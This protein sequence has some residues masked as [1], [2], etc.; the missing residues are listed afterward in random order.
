MTNLLTIESFA[1][2]LEVNRLIT[3]VAHQSDNVGK[4]YYNDLCE[5]F[6]A[7][8]Y[9]TPI[10]SNEDGTMPAELPDR[11]LCRR[12]AMPVDFLYDL[13]T[14]SY[15]LDVFRSD[16]DLIRRIQHGKTEQELF[17]KNS[18]TLRIADVFGVIEP[19]NFYQNEETGENNI[20]GA[21]A[22]SFHIYLSFFADSVDF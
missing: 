1:E 16:R 12:T 10:F 2:M 15:R 20:T 4:Q 11:R 6:E 21:R 9:N 17:R 19:K 3:E 5:T 8:E 13:E 7:R 18:S 22:A 14:D